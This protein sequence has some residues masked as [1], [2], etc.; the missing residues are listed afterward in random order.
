M[1]FEFYTGPQALISV[2]P[3]PVDEWLA[4]QPGEFAIVQMPVKVALSGAQMFY[5]RYHGKHIISGYGTF[6]P[7]LFEQRY[8]E[9]ADFPNDASL[10][11]LQA[12]PVKYVLVDHADMPS[13]LGAAIKSQPR[14]N[15]VV[16]VG[17]VD[18]YALAAGK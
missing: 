8:P 18:V 2:G 17:D 16:T 9:L 10:R 13:E 3:R 7:I 11:R 5:T 15:L 4:H 6:F 1:L 14:L 12:W